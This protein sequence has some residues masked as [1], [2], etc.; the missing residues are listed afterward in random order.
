M[1][2]KDAHDLRAYSVKLVGADGTV[3]VF[4][5]K[6]LTSQCAEALPENL[7]QIAQDA[8]FALRTAEVEAV[9]ADDYDRLMEEVRVFLTRATAPKPL[10]A[11][12]IGVQ[13]SSCK[14]I[15]P[16][17]EAVDNSQLAANFMT[18]D[19]IAGDSRCEACSRQSIENCYD[20]RTDWLVCND[21]NFRF[22]CASC[23]G[24]I[25]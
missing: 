24:S 5:A 12:N 25:K 6:L 20:C 3:A 18:G 11:V 7:R 4:L 9:T 17:S 15:V 1:T 14:T 22:V 16:L 13:C 23:R 8:G 10:L 19:P 2:L 21:R